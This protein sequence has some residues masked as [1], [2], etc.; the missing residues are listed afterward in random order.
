[1]TCPQIVKDL[2]NKFSQNY[3][4]YKSPEYNETSVRREFIDPFF[5]SLGWD[6]DNEAGLDEEFKDVIHED[7]VRVGESSRAPDYSFRIGGRRIFFV[8]AKKPYV[9]L[10]E[11]S[12]PAFQVRRY[13]YSAQLKV[14]ILTDFE[15]FSVYDVTVK[16]SL[17]EKASTR[18]LLYF[19]FNQYEEKWDEI[20]ALFSK[21]AI[22]HG[23]IRRYT[24]NLTSGKKQQGTQGLDKDFLTEIEGWREILARNIALRNKDLTQPELNLA[25]QMTI[26]RILFLRICEDRGIEPFG[27]LG[28][29]V[30]NISHYQSLISLF[31]NAD[32]KY[33]SGLF[34]FSD[35]DGKGTHDTLT[36]SLV[37]DDAPLKEIIKHLYWP[38]PYV[39]SEIPAVILGQVY[40]QFLGKVIRLT[41]DHHA[42][43][44]DKPEV[45]KAGG[46]FYTP[47]YIVD[48]IVE[49]AVGTLVEGKTPKEVSDIHILD[50][51]C[52]SGSFLIGAYQFLLDWHKRWYTENLAPLLL[53]GKRSTDREVQ[54]LIPIVNVI[55][56]KRKG[57]K[58][59]NEHPL[60]VYKMTDT[61]WHLTTSEKKRILL[62]NIYGV[63]IDTQAVE[64]TKLSLLLKV[65]EGESGERIGQKKLVTGRVLPSLD[66]NIRCGNSLLNADILMDSSLDSDILRSINPFDWD[67]E[68]ESI[69]EGGGFDVVI[70]NPPYVIITKDTHTD[71]EANYLKQYVVSQYKVDLYHLFIEKGLL[72]LRNDGILG[73]IVPNQWLTE[74]YTSKL[75]KYILDYS[76]INEV[77]VFGHY[78]FEKAKVFTALIL[79][80]KGEPHIENV[81][82]VKVIENV[83]SST[84]I[85]ESPKYECNQG[86]W[87]SNADYQF[88]TRLLGKKGE[89]IKTLLTKF[90]PL[91]VI[92]RASLGCQAY[93]LSKHTKDEIEKRVF[94]SDIKLNDEYL[95]ELAGNDI[96]RYQITKT[97]G[98]WIRYGPWLH[99]YRTIDWLTGPRILIREITNKPPYVIQACYE[100]ETYCNYKTILNVNPSD[101]T[102]V[103]MKYILGILNSK[104]ISII[105]PLIS[106]KLVSS[107]F[108]RLSVGDLKKL[109]IRHID[110]NNPQDIEYH[111]KMV[112]LVTRMLDLNKQLSLS[113]LSNEKDLIQ[114]QIEGT[115]KAIDVLV[116]DLY[117]LT[118]DEVRIIEKAVK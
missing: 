5:K 115:D 18:R 91:S 15:E 68:F 71:I 35:E 104:L 60:P 112:A 108:P 19:T 46:V 1:M 107:A 7:A 53:E 77:T 80:Q 11:S 65:L 21:D 105:Y 81:I 57:K 106:N 51:A 76:N 72:L 38:T 27:Q 69:M 3:S 116:Y 64:V 67:R 66:Q 41:P 42:K 52:G 95:P 47:T 25:V 30:E 78:V 43:V 29:A 8:E 101:D 33:N 109:P 54:D 13:G 6:I 56:G 26:D 85:D 79:L 75:R 114:R 98:S 97:R 39:F 20:A 59:G 12:E 28:K 14:S 31:K 49:K 62:N 61:D 94:H 86:E 82:K 84:E 58:S 34:H 88:E 37:I 102:Q 48:Y 74:K 63:D 10:K 103:S 110:F 96:Q 92:A 111:E 113:R 17:S 4:Q 117:E 40:E 100:E 99:D 83:S 16:P 9:N 44:E 87:D 2:V 36:L 89:I 23:S 90:P 55:T 50:P 22:Q 45:K 32:A 24:E 118:E 70:G 93:N 73:Y